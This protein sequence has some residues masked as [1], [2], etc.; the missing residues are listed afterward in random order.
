MRNCPQHWPEPETRTGRVLVDDVMVSIEITIDWARLAWDLAHR[1]ARNQS[2]RASEMA[3]AI[4]AKR[5][6]KEA[7]S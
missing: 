5:S 3:G 1:V 4:K 7:A 2:G 6:K